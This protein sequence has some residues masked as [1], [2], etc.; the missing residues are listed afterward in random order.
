MLKGDI[1]GNPATGHTQGTATLIE[2][3]EYFPYQIYLSE[4][5]VEGGKR[6]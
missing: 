2:S 6:F 3:V 4:M 1:R 5:G